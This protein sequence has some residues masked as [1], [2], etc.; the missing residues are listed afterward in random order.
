MAH[1][2]MG[3][4]RVDANMQ[5]RFERTL[6]R[7]RSGRRRQRRQSLVGQRHHRGFC[8]WPA[9]RFGAGGIFGQAKAL[10]HG[11]SGRAMRIDRL[12]ALCRTPQRSAVSPD[13]LQIELQNLMWEQAGP[14]RTAINSPRRWLRIRQMRERDLPERRRRRRASFNLDLQDWFELRAM[15]ATAEAVVRS[16]LA[17]TESRGAHQREDFPARDDSCLTKL[18]SKIRCLSLQTASSRR[19]GS[20]RYLM[21]QLGMIENLRPFDPPRG[22]KAK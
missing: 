18:F 6:C 3:G 22:L 13:A 10:W 17:R 1:Y 20:I 9:R 16:A 12:R 15:L 21:S 19:R 14:F 4:I 5:T 8:L 11:T 2:H 7:R